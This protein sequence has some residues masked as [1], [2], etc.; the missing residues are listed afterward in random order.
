MNT[1][2]RFAKAR[3]GAASLPVIGTGTLADN[4]GRGF[5]LLLD[6]D[7]RRLILH[8]DGARQIRFDDLAAAFA[9]R[10]DD[11]SA[12]PGPGAAAVALSEETRPEAPGLVRL[13]G[14]LHR[15]VNGWAIVLTRPDGPALNL[16][17]LEL[18]TAVANGELPADGAPVPKPARPAPTGRR[19]RK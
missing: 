4:T 1:L 12:A 13:E 14:D 11:D 15:A 2:V 16:N 9:G 5:Q 7:G 19:K 18:V 6:A 8:A 3:P 17:V 10:R